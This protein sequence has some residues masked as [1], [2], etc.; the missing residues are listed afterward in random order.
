MAA[1]GQVVTVA[2]TP[3][4]IFQVVDPITYA[5]LVSPASN[6]FKSGDGNAPLPLLLVFS[7]TNTMFFGGSTVTSSGAG[8]GA[9]MAGLS[10]FSYNCIGGD[11]LYGIVASGTQA[12]QLL[13][14]R[15]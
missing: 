12:I 11:S 1:L 3:T 2:S 6:V 4:L 8:V 9:S 15:Q 7:S 14:L 10:T 13:A 5:G